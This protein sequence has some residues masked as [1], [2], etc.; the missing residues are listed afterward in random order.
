MSKKGGGRQA[1]V[2]AAVKR[3]KLKDEERKYIAALDQVYARLEQR[4]GGFPLGNPR[5][6]QQIDDMVQAQLDERPISTPLTTSKQRRIEEDYS[7][8]YGIAGKVK[9]IAHANLVFKIGHEEFIDRYSVNK[10]KLDG[11]LTRTASR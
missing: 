11:R 5:A 3:L 4:A 1:F 7:A 2:D 9:E 6:A 8:C 10:K